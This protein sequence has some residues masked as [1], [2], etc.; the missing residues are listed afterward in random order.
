MPVAPPHKDQRKSREQ[1]NEHAAPRTVF[2][3]YVK[4]VGT[5]GLHG[6][7]RDSRLLRAGITEADAGIGANPDH[8][9]IRPAVLI[10]ERKL[11]GERFSVSSVGLLCEPLVLRPF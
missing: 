3:G 1:Q 4:R 11:L 8:P 5:V 9:Q 7:Q 10:A 6:V 2:A